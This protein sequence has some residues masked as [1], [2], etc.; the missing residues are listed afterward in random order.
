MR[1]GGGLGARRVDRREEGALQSPGLCGGRGQPGTLDARCT[2]LQAGRA[3]EV[4]R[5]RAEMQNVPLPQMAQ[6]RCFPTGGSSSSEGPFPPPLDLAALPS[7]LWKQAPPRVAPTPLA[8]LA[9]SR[10]L[11]VALAACVS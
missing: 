2:E 9:G 8:G 5:R 11:I 7:A 1:E 10:I 6:H 3:A 4:T